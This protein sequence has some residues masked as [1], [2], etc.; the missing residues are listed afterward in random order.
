MKN[1]F[2]LGTV[3]FGLKYGINNAIDRQPSKNEC[4]DI[5]DKA[6]ECDI[7]YFDTASVYGNAEE[8][9]GAYGKLNNKK[10][11]SK[12]NP[13]KSFLSSNM[14][15]SV[16]KDC[17]ATLKKLNISLL[18]GYL[19]HAPKDMYNTQVMQGLLSCK[20]KGLVKN[21]GVSIYDPK[22]AVYAVENLDIDYIQ[23]PY[24]VLD[25][26]LNKTIFFSLTKK[27]NIKVFAR[28]CYLQGLL[29]MSFKD[30]SN[31]MPEILKY[32]KIFD[33]ICK[34]YKYTR[35][36]AAFLFSYMNDN[37][38]YLV[39]GVDTKEQL[40]ENINIVKINNFKECYY[41]LENIFYDISEA[42]IN[43]SLWK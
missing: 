23:I 28:S 38:D 17:E 31:K 41:A 1:K 26:R 21:I 15:D 19:L 37:I 10:I 6:I 30:I 12:L 25:Q 33:D 43:P 22:D 3:Q 8:I 4:F 2:C 7:E 36:E 9:L 18:D 14:V 39:F 32:I 42:I 16:I 13:T 24:N 35:K 34:K 11:I 27:Y 40:I 29:T 20:E 5:L